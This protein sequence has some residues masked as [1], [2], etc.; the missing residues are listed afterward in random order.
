MKIKLH[1]LFTSWAVL[2]KVSQFEIE[3]SQAI[4][5]N[6]FMQSAE[7]EHSLIETQRLRLVQQFGEES[8]DLL[9]E[10]VWS[11]SK[12]RESEFWSAF[13]PILAEE[14]EI[15]NPAL[16]ADTLAGQ[17]MSAIDFFAIAFLFKNESESE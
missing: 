7:K 11:V 15:Y 16:S 2:K 13:S 14:I 17:K 1:Q 4:R 12:E 6:R 9:G 10:S 5:L 3:A 8:K